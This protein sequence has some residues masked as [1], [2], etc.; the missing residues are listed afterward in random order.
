MVSILVEAWKLRKAWNSP[1]NIASS[2][3]AEYDRAGFR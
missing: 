3:T 2:K 1:A